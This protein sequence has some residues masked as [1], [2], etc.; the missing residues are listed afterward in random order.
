MAYLVT[1][2]FKVKRGLFT[3]SETLTY[4]FLLRRTDT[5]SSTFIINSFFI[6]LFTL[7]EDGQGFG[8]TY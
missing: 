5:L 1:R 4:V 6:M 2:H 8:Q 7:K 3:C